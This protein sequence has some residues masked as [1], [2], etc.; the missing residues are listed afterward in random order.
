MHHVYIIAASSLRGTAKSTY[1]ARS[2]VGWL[3]LGFLTLAV[4][5]LLGCQPLKG[6]KDPKKV[7]TS[8]VHVE[9]LSSSQHPKTLGAK[10]QA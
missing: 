8:R 1:L 4:F 5:P 10:F 3:I 6:L 2:L 7:R 9:E